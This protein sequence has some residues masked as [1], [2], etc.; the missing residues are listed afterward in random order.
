MMKSLDERKSIDDVLTAATYSESI[1][2][3]EVERSAGDDD[4]DESDD[5]NELRQKRDE[6]GVYRRVSSRRDRHRPSIGAELCR[7]HFSPRW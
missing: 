2:S 7:V 5:E 6:V 4:D 1:R 3:D